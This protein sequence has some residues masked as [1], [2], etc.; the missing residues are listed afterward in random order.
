MAS[1]SW[2]GYKCYYSSFSILFHFARGFHVGS[3][4][5]CVFVLVGAE[6]IKGR[7]E[8]QIKVRQDLHKV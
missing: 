4:V 3:E 7:F 5:V 2:H 6:A 1:I 8:V